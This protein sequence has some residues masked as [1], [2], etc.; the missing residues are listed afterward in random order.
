MIKMVFPS[1]DFRFRE[2]KGQRQIFDIIRK[3]WVAFQPEEWVRQNVVRWLM[4]LHKIPLQAIALEKEI[5]VAGAKRRFDLLVY[6][7]NILP[8]MLVEC[9]SPSI[10]LDDAALLQVLAYQQEIPVPHLMITNG[11]ETHILEKKAGN[12][13]WISCFP[14]YKSLI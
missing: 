14:T 12:P 2:Q 9:K 4:D 13:A 3:K 7:A 8:W 6:D 5:R 10:R 11:E 1:P